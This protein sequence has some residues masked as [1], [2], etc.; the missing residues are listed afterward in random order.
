MVRDP[1]H[2]P[3]IEP[4]P[5]EECAFAVVGFKEPYSVMTGAPDGIRLRDALDDLNFTALVNRCRLEEIMRDPRIKSIQIADTDGDV[6]D[7]GED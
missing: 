3:V 4:I 5:E 7:S 1:R 6:A 2:F